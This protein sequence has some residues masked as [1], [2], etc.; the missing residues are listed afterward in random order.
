MEGGGW[1]LWAKEKRLQ[2]DGVTERGKA[3][4]NDKGEEVAEGFE[5]EEQVV[6]VGRSEW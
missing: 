2:R 4:D 5:S 3:V 1:R 6:E